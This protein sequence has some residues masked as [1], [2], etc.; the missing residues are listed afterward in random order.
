MSAPRCVNDRLR[1]LITEVGW[2][3]GELA[4]AVNMVAAETGLRLS[5]GRA[6][7]GQWLAGARPRSPGPELVAEALSRALRRPVAVADTGLSRVVAAGEG[8]FDVRMELVH[9]ADATSATRRDVLRHCVYNLGALAAAGI[10]ESLPVRDFSGARDVGRIGRTEVEAAAAAL[11]L[12]SDAEGVLGAGIMRRPLADYLAGTVAPWLA[13]ASTATVRQQFLSVAAELAYLC[14]FMCF[15]DELHGAAQRYY[16]LSLRLS[17]EA[18]DVRGYAVALRSM[19]SQAYILGHYRQAADLA[20]AA[21]ET[22]ATKVSPSTKAF[23]AGQLAVSAAATEDSGAATAHLI[24]AER[25]LDGS[26]DPAATTGAY[27]HAS[28][29]HQRAVVRARLGDKVGAIAALAESI[30]RRPAGEQR[31]EVIMLARRAELQLD[32]GHVEEAAVTWGRFVDVYPAVRSGRACTALRT[33][34][35]RLRPYQKIPLIGSLLHQ[36]ATLNG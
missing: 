17:G 8:E 18:E 36:A 10:A 34:K 20:E 24:A 12:F 29:A 9:L 27:H 6:S 3:G 33:M 26:S 21:V 2:S 23:L 25:H 31:A 15:D 1:S 35:A 22:A 28:L 16:R 30:R 11:R 13:A 4:K 19:S 5:Y 32:C 7:V 14:G